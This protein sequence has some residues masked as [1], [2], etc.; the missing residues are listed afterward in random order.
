MASGSKFVS[1]FLISSFFFSFLHLLE[2]YRVTFSV[3]TLSR[4]FYV[5]VFDTRLHVFILYTIVNFG[6]FA[7]LE[8]ILVSNWIFL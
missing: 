8:S 5:N 2:F 7:C 6:V 1:L 4:S 3:S